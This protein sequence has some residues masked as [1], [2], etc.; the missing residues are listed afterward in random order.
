[1]EL[2]VDNFAGGGG[3]STGIELAVGRPVDIAINHDPDAIAMHKVNHPFTRHYCESVWEV[4]PKEICEGNPVGLMW[5]SPEGNYA[6]I[7]Q[8][9]E[10][11]FSVE[12]NFDTDTAQLY[13]VNGGKGGIA[14]NDRTDDNIRLSKIKISEYT[15]DKTFAYSYG[16]F[17]VVHLDLGTEERKN[18]VSEALKNIINN[19][20]NGKMNG[21]QPYKNLLEQITPAAEFMHASQGHLICL[22]YALQNAESSKGQVV[23]VQRERWRRQHRL[24]RK[25]SQYELQGSG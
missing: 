25:I 9:D 10:F 7:Q 1:M 16:S 18:A 14:E 6:A 4:N 2:I 17:N 22:E 5:L 21:V 11:T 24:L 23:Q 3:A 15:Q 13:E 19:V 8:S 20:Y 12:M